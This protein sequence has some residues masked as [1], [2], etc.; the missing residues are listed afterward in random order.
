MENVEV[1]VTKLEGKIKD[2]KQYMIS[3]A[4]A[5]GF[6]HPHTVKISQDLD[7]LLNKYQTIDSK[8]CS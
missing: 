7:K 5:K 1:P 6:N 8:L 3:T 2:L 4:Y